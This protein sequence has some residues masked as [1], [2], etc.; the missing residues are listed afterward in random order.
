MGGRDL[1]AEARSFLAASTATADAEARELY[2]ARARNAVTA[3][4]QDTSVLGREVAVAE[5]ELV[6]LNRSRATA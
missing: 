2:V 5:A 6:R 1:L 3:L 4:E